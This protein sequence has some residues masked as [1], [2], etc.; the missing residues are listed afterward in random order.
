MDKLT[1][2]LLV[3][4]RQALAEPGE[5]RL[6]RAGKLSGLFASRTAANGE[7][8]A[9][10]IRDGLLEVVRTETKGKT[11]TEWVKITPRGVN[12]LHE[13]DSPLEVLRELR[14]VLRTNQQGVPAWLADLRLELQ[15]LGNR[16]LEEVQRYV[17]R[18]DALEKRVD[19]ALRR[20]DAAGPSLPDGLTQSLPWALEALAYLDRRTASGANGECP[21]PELFAA[22]REKHDD[23]E[24]PVFHGG[25]RQLHDRRALRLLPAADP[26]QPLPEPEHALLD[27]DAVY[28]YAGR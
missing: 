4:L 6:F 11:A 16:L 19:E 9:Q 7:A 18:L 23:L 21:L 15:S 14:N 28:Y 12:F 22:L 25:L 2:A 3:A 26:D 13:Q 17:Q 1:D 27:G 8:A 20:A 5:Q 24:L 10:A